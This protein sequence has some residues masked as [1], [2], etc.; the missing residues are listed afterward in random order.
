MKDAHHRLDA[1]V[2]EAYGMK[3]E[4]DALTFLLQLNEELT[5]NEA[6]SVPLVAPGLPPVVEE[7]QRYVTSDRVQMSEQI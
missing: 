7:P 5:G 2:R 3:S 6:N 4:E 1:A